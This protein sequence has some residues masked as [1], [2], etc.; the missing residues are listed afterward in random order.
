MATGIL[1]QQ[2]RDLS[3]ISFPD[4]GHL[5]LRVDHCHPCDITQAGI[6]PVVVQVISE[7]G[8]DESSKTGVGRNQGACGRR[9]DEGSTGADEIVSTGRCKS[10]QRLY[11][12][13]AADA[14]PFRDVL[15]VPR[16]H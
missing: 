1:D 4:Q 14:Y 16:Q 11:S 6:V 5:Q 7:H 9:Y 3:S 15:S 8:K 10:D 2:V 13:I 12:G